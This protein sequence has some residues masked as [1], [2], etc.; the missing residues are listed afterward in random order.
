MKKVKNQ[1]LKEKK[2][3]KYGEKIVLEDAIV[4]KGSY[5]ITRSKE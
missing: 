5:I 2:T 1:S 4:K 3:R